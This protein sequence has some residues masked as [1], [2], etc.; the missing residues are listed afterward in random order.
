MYYHITGIPAECMDSGI[1][2][3]FEITNIV[4]CMD[5]YMNGSKIFTES[6]VAIKQ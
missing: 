2:N 4:Y 3:V 5:T 6:L 1:F